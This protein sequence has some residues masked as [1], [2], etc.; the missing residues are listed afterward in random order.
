MHACVASPLLGM[1]LFQFLSLLVHVASSAAAS[2]KE[3][4]IAQ[5]IKKEAD[6]MQKD[7]KNMIDTK[8]F[9]NAISM[10]QEKGSK[11]LVQYGAK[12]WPMAEVASMLADTYVACGSACDRQGEASDLYEKSASLK[13]AIYGEG[14]PEYA[15]AVEKTA[16]AL[17]G[18]GSHKR[19]LPYFRKLVRSVSVG[20][21]EDHEALKNVRMKLANC[22]MSTK[23]YKTAKKTW[24]NLLRGSLAPGDEIHARLHLGVALAQLTEHSAASQQVEAAKTFIAK[25]YGKRHM[26]YAKALNAAAGVLERLHRDEDA[27]RSMQE[28]SELVASLLGPED[29]MSV[30]ARRNVEGLKSAIAAK[31]LHEASA[32]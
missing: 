21:G 23:S 27:L 6:G 17:V 26:E 3:R 19:A 24:T 8:Q 14:A 22:A 13:L 15:A 9:R 31:G 2:P 7:V 5:A 28:A 29:P 18:A 10:L 25:H 20:L 16:D 4:A 1:R 12:S 11:W 30:Q 32:A